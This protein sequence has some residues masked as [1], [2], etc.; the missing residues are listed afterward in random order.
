VKTFHF[1]YQGEIQNSSVE[2]FKEGEYNRYRILLKDLTLVIASAGFR[3]ASGKIIWVQSVK[4]RE[5]VQPHDFIQAIGE[6]LE[7]VL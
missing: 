4:P 6:G 7:Q 2:I 3:D 1:K 5:F